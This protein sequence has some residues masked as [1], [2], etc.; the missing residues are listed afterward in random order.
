MNKFE[1]NGNDIELIYLKFL[2]EIILYYESVKN[3]KNDFKFE[4]NIYLFNRVY[5]ISNFRFK[6]FVQLFLKLKI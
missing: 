1:S 3:V 2:F 6:K 4:L 5:E